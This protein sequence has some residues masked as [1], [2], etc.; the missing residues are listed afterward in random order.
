MKFQLF[1]DLH[2][3]LLDEL[4]YNTFINSIIP[5]TNILILAGDICNIHHKYFHQFMEFCDN[6][7][8]DVYYVLG[9]HEYYSEIN[10][11]YE[12]KK[13]YEFELLSYANITLL[14]CNKAIINY[15]NETT[16]ENEEWELLGCTLWSK[17]I[18]GDSTNLSILT[19][20]FDNI[21]E[22]RIIFEKDINYENYIKLTNIDLYNKL[23][24]YKKQFYDKQNNESNNIDES[25]NQ[26]I[27]EHDFYKKLR[28][29]YTR[30]INNTE[31]K[32]I[33]SLYK[34]DEYNND[35]KFKEFP[36]NLILP[37][38]AD[39]ECFKNTGYEN[40]NPTIDYYKNKNKLLLMKPITI[41]N[42]N[43]INRN[44]KAWLYENYNPKK[45][46]IFLTHYPL[47]HMCV[48]SPKYMYQTFEQQA[49][50][51]NIKFIDELLYKN[52]DILDNHENNNQC[53]TKTICIAG[54][55][56]YSYDFIYNLNKNV[57]FIANQRGYFDET[58]R[59]NYFNLNKVFEI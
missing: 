56:H 8:Q 57:R 51:T 7:W 21:Q 42:Y 5:K 9:N 10:T 46:T 20:C 33:Y 28:N 26:K 12:L 22:T 47:N 38:L 45:N 11:Y 6:N 18:N 1:S 44:E 39:L 50:F 34:F 40:D 35:N 31:K 59:F 29:N 13:I 3:E 41:T 55:T 23:M 2:L 49:L 37:P 16:G 25:N 24:K 30:Y 14:D 53:K 54:H 19:N 27:I 4:K 58:D 32:D 36:N 17:I 43:K 48:S 15:K 52:Q